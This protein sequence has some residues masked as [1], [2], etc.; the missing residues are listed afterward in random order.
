LGQK[1][2]FFLLNLST[3]L[4]SLGIFGEQEVQ[5]LI[6]FKLELVE[7]L[8]KGYFSLALGLA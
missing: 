2:K 1:E 4:Q 3:P 7:I 5:L 6:F 8:E